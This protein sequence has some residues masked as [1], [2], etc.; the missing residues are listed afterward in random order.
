VQAALKFFVMDRIATQ[1]EKDLIKT[2]KDQE[3][4]YSL[5]S[6][7]VKCVLSSYIKLKKYSNFYL[8]LFLFEGKIIEEKNT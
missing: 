2:V 4:T 3:V 7:K 5:P 8:Y 1:L 6:A